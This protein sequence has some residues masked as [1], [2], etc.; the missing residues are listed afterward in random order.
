MRAILLVDH[1]SRREESN[2]LLARVASM[3][4]EQVGEDV[5]V[6]HAHM[7][8]AEPDIA[9][10]FDA[11]V[12]DGAS[13]VIVHPYFLSTGRHVTEDIPRL[14]ASAAKAHPDVRYRVT[15]PLGLHS[16]IGAV[17][18]ERCGLDPRR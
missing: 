12:R 3:V 2:E 11:C 4:R 9:A 6:H 7:E 14:V 18:L 8:I 13:E 1:G 15:A 16:A 10:G 5:V 17:I